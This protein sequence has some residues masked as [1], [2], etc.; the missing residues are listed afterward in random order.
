MRETI[1]TRGVEAPRV[2]VNRRDGAEAQEW[3]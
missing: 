1:G 2:R 3:D